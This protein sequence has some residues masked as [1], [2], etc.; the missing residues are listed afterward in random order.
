M[1]TPPSCPPPTPRLSGRA[2]LFGC[3]RHSPTQRSQDW[4]QGQLTSLSHLPFID[5]NRCSFFP[6]PHSQ[7]SR[8]EKGG[9]GGGRKKKK[10]RKKALPVCHFFPR[11][12]KKKKGCTSGGDLCCQTAL[13]ELAAVKKFWWRPR[14]G[15]FSLS[16]TPGSFCLY[17]LIWG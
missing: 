8:L 4:A 1:R 9:R 16:S 13:S 3:S 14:R 5:L 7:I 15:C 12:G 6:L 17:A 10:E 11:Q 2:L